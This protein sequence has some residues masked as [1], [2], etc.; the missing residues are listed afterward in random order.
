MNSATTTILPKLLRA[1]YW[2]DEGLRQTQQ[3]MGQTPVSRAQAM[4]LINIALGE[5][6]PVRLARALG[7]TKQ[8][9]SLM[10]SDLQAAGRISIVPDP[11]DARASLVEFSPSGAQELGVIFDTLQALEA[12]LAEV[13]GS[14][15]MAVLRAALDM[16]WGPPPTFVPADGSSH[17]TSLETSGS[18]ADTSFDPGERRRPPRVG[19]PPKP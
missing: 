4:L 5:R 14:D 13:I 11:A 12:H 15:R 3:R 7:V 19:R 6:R 2:F 17:S 10:L 9:V 1:I 16:E 18:D 8:A